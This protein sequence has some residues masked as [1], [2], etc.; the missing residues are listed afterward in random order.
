MALFND[1]PPSALLKVSQDQI[2]ERPV[3][4]KPS[5]FGSR[6]ETLSLALTT[7][8]ALAVNAELGVIIPVPK[9]E[10]WAI[11]AARLDITCNVPAAVWKDMAVFLLRKQL[12]GALATPPDIVWTPATFKTYIQASEVLAATASFGAAFVEWAAYNDFG[13]TAGGQLGLPVWE[14]DDEVAFRFGNNGVGA[15]TVTGVGI[16]LL[17]NRIPLGSTLLEELRRESVSDLE[18]QRKLQ[19]VAVCG[20][21][22]MPV[23]K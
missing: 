6:V 13:L 18:L 7:T 17:L 4:G 15:Q 19:A 22:S 8:T 23:N 10:V 20:I 16:K 5:L 3:I 14:G 11:R 9:G 12:V 21:P 1:L 2:E